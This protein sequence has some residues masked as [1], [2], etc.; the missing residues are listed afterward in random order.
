MPRMVEAQ[1]PGLDKYQALKQAQQA[2]LR[3][4]AA[5]RDQLQ[6]KQVQVQARKTDLDV[7]GKVMQ[8][9]D[10]RIPKSARQFLNT[11]LAQYVGVDPKNDAFKGVNSMMMG[12]DP[13]SAQDL[14]TQLGSQLESAQPGQ[15]LEMTRGLMTGQLPLS[16]F[17]SQVSF[18]GGEGQDSLAGGEGG[19]QLQKPAASTSRTAQPFQGGPASVQSFEGQRTT[20]AASQQASPMLVG[21]LGLDS[22]VRLRNNDL[23][24]QGYRVPFDPKDQEKLAEGIVTRS[25]GLSSTISEAANMV[26]LFQGK[27]EVLGPVGQIA[28]GISGT[29]NQVQGFFNLIRPGTTVEGPDQATQDVADR[30]GLKMLKIHGIDA[31][32]ESSARI[33][34]MVLGLAYRMAVANDIPGNRLTNGIIQQNLEQLGEASSPAQFQAVLKDTIT[35]TSREFNEHIRR[36]VGVDGLPLWARQV[37]NNDI[38]RLAKAGSVLPNDMALALRD[39]AAKRLRGETTTQITPASPTLQ[40]EE[41]T[42][43]NVEMQTKERKI[44]QTEQEMDLAQRRDQRAQSAEQRAEGRE[45]RMAEAQIRQA[46]IQQRQLDLQSENTKADNARAER[47]L[48]LQERNISEDNARAQRAEGFQRE[49]FEY[50][51]AQ[52]RREEDERN[53]K[54]IQ[55]AFLKF[56]QAIAGLGQGG[57]VSLGGGGGGGGGQDQSAFRITPAPQRQAPSIPG[58]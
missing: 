29:I 36:T 55:D 57:G 46:D 53:R 7:A 4:H 34:S 27:P 45:D 12:L 21:A 5:F 33:R 9:L 18:S 22:R 43:G 44:Q 56:G 47:Q 25:T 8:I 26:D 15:V 24:T 39:E 10:T 2:S 32:A 40:E 35:A 13:Q 54:V 23:Y 17:L 19:D 3:Q 37:P 41:Q 20:P 28:R 58:K 42:L 1:I 48:Q 30:I 14:K 50:K 31:T 51:K 49:Q 52:D 6:Q 38:L 16:T 11:Q